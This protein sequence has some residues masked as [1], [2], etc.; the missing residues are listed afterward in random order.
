MNWRIEPGNAS[1]RPFLPNGSVNQNT[2][3]WALSITFSLTSTT[4]STPTLARP[5]P[6]RGPRGP[7]RPPHP[8]ALK[9]G[10][11]GQEPASKPSRADIRMEIDVEAARVAEQLGQRQLR[12]GEV[13]VGDKHALL[14]H[15]D[16]LLGEVEIH[17]HGGGEPPDDGAS[18]LPRGQVMDVPEPNDLAAFVVDGRRC[19]DRAVF[20]NLDLCMPL[21]FGRAGRDLEL[22]AHLRV[23][24]GRRYQ[25]ALHASAQRSATEHPAR[26]R[27]IAASS[28]YECC[29][30]RTPVTHTASRVVSC[31]EGREW[32]AEPTAGR[33]RGPGA[34]GGCGTLRITRLASF[35]LSETTTLP[36]AR[37]A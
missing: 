16:V 27:R 14:L 24:H 9:N 35:H 21:R 6:K 29:Q 10:A 3:P 4:R 8:S 36:L 34:G 7:L 23:E 33:A 2:G 20:Q 31:P 11:S 1:V 22:R 12:G 13:R 15:V 5:V 28:N 37:P 25:A 17:P 26:R 18:G 19:L 32:L 30:V